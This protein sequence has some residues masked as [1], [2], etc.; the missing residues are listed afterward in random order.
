MRAK[1]NNK[2]IWTGSE[3]DLNNFLIDLTDLEAE[4]VKIER[5]AAGEWKAVEINWSMVR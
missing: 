3:E 4:K 1:I 2:V 5:L